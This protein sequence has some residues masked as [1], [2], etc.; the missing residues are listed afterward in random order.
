MTLHP[1][2][3]LFLLLLSTVAA[4]DGQARKT[5]VKLPGQVVSVEA[6]E[7]FLRAPDTISS[8]LTTFVLRQVGDMLTNRK[9]AIAENLAPASPGNDPTRAF[10]MVWV[11]RLDSG[12][13]VTEW[14]DAEMKG[15]KVSWATHL[16]GPSM[17]EPPMTS[18][19]TMVLR[20]GNYALVCRVGSAR[21]DK[22]RSHL[23]KGMFRP[24]TVRASSAAAQVLPDGDVSAVISG[25][26]EVKLTGTLR[27]GMQ[28][29][30]VTNTTEKAYEFTVHRVKPGRTATEAV[31][32]RRTDGADHP[33][34]SS[35]GF[36]D[37][38]PGESRITTISFAP[39]TYALWTVRSPRTSV[40]VT[41]PAS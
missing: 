10:H 3:T 31:T 24:L 21:A 20:P 35:G 19:A 30:R 16:G 12:H 36:S 41:I 23:M 13:T 22:N 9:K 15:E 18:N 14:Y 28:S 38:P 5:E 4:A 40:T 32:W 34:E 29:I 11:V 7:F 6:G 25:T 1:I 37:V 33:F 2:G 27:K 8:G 39:G 17:A 26:G